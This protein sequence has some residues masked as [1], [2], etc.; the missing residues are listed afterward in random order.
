MNEID[1]VSFGAKVYIKDKG[2]CLSLMQKLK[3]KR[4]AKQIGDDTD[5]IFIGTRKY[6]NIDAFSNKH[7]KKSDGIVLSFVNKKVVD[8]RF[9]SDNIFESLADYIKTFSN[10][11]HNYWIVDSNVADK[12]TTHLKYQLK[13]FCSL[14]RTYHKTSF[15]EVI[16]KLFTRK[17]NP[18]KAARKAKEEKEFQDWLTHE[19]YKKETEEDV[20]LAGEFYDTFIKPVK[21]ELF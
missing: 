21:D 5:S 19:R 10:V 3:L 6:D 12:V 8:M 20:D 17:P 15:S 9:D 13:E 16:K 1:N 7:F 14:K 4:L 2:R 11:G 18:E